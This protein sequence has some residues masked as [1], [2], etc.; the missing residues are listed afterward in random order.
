MARRKSVKRIDPR[1]FLH[2]TVNRGEELEEECKDEEGYERPLE[3]GLAEEEY[4]AEG[5]EEAKDLYLMLV[6]YPPNHDDWKGGYNKIILGLTTGGGMIV[7][8]VEVPSYGLKNLHSFK[9]GRFDGVTAEDAKMIKKYILDNPES[10]PAAAKLIQDYENKFASLAK[11]GREK[12]IEDY[13]FLRMWNKANR[14]SRAASA[15]DAF[16]AAFGE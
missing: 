4:L 2:E 5:K 15:G 13:A 16:D 8:D 7:D 12:D 3:A 6:K 14:Q 1:Y 11:G 10:A 9:K